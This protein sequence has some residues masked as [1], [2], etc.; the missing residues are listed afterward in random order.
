MSF[1]AIGFV[2]C[3]NLRKM[4]MQLSIQQET[5]TSLFAIGFLRLNC[6]Y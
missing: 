4:P 3:N 6:N 2:R 1:F 5:E